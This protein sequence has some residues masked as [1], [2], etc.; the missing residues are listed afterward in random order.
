MEGYLFLQHTDC[1]DQP[2]TLSNKLLL[3]KPI[4]FDEN[5]EN[6]I[7][8]FKIKNCPTKHKFWIS[9]W[10]DYSYGESINF[11]DSR[12]EIVEKSIEQLKID[13]QLNDSVKPPFDMESYSDYTI[14]KLKNSDCVVLE[15][16]PLEPDDDDLSPPVL[17]IKEVVSD[18][19]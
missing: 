15:H 1:S 19:F 9:M 11:A 18:F 5:N 2:I 4:D 14:E 17:I 10:Y 16:Y 3:S 6:D 8:L 7:Y 13:Y 12:K